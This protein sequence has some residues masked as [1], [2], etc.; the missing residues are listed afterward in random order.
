M[1]SMPIALILAAGPPRRRP[2]AR[3]P[4]P[5][6][7]PTWIGSPWFTRTRRRSLADCGT[8][9]TSSRPPRP[10]KRTTARSGLRREA[11]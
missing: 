2:A 8:W 9:P 1:Y 3:S 4:T 10:V 11:G 7:C 5:P 6:S